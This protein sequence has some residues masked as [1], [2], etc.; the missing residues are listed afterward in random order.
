M[1]EFGFFLV[2]I[3]SVAEYEI[4]V[5]TPVDGFIIPDYGF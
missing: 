2:I 4:I 5:I 3:P 1:V